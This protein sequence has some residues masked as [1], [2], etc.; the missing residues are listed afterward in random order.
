MAINYTFKTVEIF[1]QGTIER[2]GS[3]LYTGWILEKVP[4]NK[5]ITVARYY[6]VV[7]ITVLDNSHYPRVGSR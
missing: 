7:Y 6:P 2:T 5:L 1:L 4:Q 3:E